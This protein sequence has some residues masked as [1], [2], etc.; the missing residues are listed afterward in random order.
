[1]TRC[2]KSSATTVLRL[3]WPGSAAGARSSVSSTAGLQRAQGRPTCPRVLHSVIYQR[4]APSGRRVADAPALQV[5]V[6]AQGAGARRLRA[7]HRDQQQRRARAQGVGRG[8]HRLRRAGQH[9]RRPELQPP[10]HPRPHHLQ[11]KELHL[12]DLTTVAAQCR[13]LQAQLEERG[14]SL[15]ACGPRRWAAR[16]GRGARRW[17]CSGHDG[18]AAGGG[19]RQGRPGAVRRGAGRRPR[20]APIAEHGARE[21]ALRRE[22][23]GVRARAEEEGG[24]L[25][26]EA[27]EERAR[28]ASRATSLEAASDEAQRGRGSS[29]R[30]ARRRRGRAP[31]SRLRARALTLLVKV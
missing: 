1:M 10:H 14:G 5:H 24:L 20:R 2:G 4:G 3:P 16:R 30:G 12:G 18:G 25:E 22:L 9:H 13:G 27:A 31:L 21:E 8:H 23:D 7:R 17:T 28:A 26:G 29:S 15:Q 11:E 6:Q 19:H